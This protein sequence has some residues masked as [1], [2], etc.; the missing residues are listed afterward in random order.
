MDGGERSWEKEEWREFIVEGY[1]K[2]LEE[3]NISLVKREELWR[4]RYELRGIREGWK[5]GRPKRC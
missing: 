2:W 3:K 5:E 1:G 4:K